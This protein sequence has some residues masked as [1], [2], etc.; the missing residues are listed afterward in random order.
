MLKG[1]LQVSRQRCH[2]AIVVTGRRVINFVGTWQPW[3]IVVSRRQHCFQT[4][5]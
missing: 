5:N 3:D 2:E 1:S 4:R